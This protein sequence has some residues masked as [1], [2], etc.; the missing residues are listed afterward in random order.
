MRPQAARFG[1]ASAVGNRHADDRPRSTRKKVCEETEFRTSTVARWAPL[2]ENDG[3]RITLRVLAW[4]LALGAVALV[5]GGLVLDE[6][7]AAQRVPGSGS[8]WLYPL[9]FAAVSTPA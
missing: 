5:A 8:V 4:G 3:V 2:D 7:A 9:F 6:I 1:E